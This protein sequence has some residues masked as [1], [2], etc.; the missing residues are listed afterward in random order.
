MT[1]TASTGSQVIS[2]ALKWINVCRET[3]TPSP[4]QLQTGI[5]VLNQMMAEW[6]VDGGSMGY[7]PIGTPTDVLPL[8]DAAVRGVTFHLAISLCIPFQTTASQELIALAVNS[9]VVLDRLRAQDVQ[10][11]LGELPLPAGMCGGGSIQTG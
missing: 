2:D 4:E 3:Q 10:A 9:M 5:R 11:N 7:I 6:E 8:P 1:P